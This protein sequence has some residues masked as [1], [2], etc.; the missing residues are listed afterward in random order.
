MQ[1]KLGAR[2]QS[3]GFY[4]F[5][6]LRSL[7]FDHDVNFMNDYRMLGLGDKTYL[8]QPTKTGHAESAWTIGPAIVWSPFFA[9]GHVVATRLHAKG[10]DVS[11]DGTSF[12]DRQAVCVPSLFYGLPASLL[13]E[14]PPRL[15]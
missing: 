13:A 14:R 2:L 8:F 10:L 1:L 6:F 9:V 4:Y 11:T 3:D 15:F 12:P 5:A 7:A